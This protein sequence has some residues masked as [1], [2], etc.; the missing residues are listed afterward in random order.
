MKG[1]GK[2]RKFKVMIDKGNGGIE[3]GE[4]RMSGI[5]EK[6]MKIE[7]GKELSERI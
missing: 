1:N 5:K 2:K 7:L 3:R 6:K 4:E